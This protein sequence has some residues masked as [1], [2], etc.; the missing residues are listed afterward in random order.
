MLAIC[1]VCC[2]EGFA[3]GEKAY[4][5][6]HTLLEPAVCPCRETCDVALDLQPQRHVEVFRHM[7]LRP[8]LDIAVLL[9]GNVLERGPA[10]HG[11]VAHEGRHVTVGHPKP[12][13]RVHEVREEGDAV[14]EVIPA[15][16]HDARRKL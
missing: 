1:L 9:E 14:L 4:S 12:D 8:E 10:E 7:R 11:V 6:R 16:L 3:N 2:F 5:Q 15:D 13:R